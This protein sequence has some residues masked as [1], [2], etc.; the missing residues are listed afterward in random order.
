MLPP[1][2]GRA[3]ELT[4]SRR[5]P[6]VPN[7]VS[8]N[9]ELDIPNDDEFAPFSMFTPPTSK[10]RGR[11]AAAPG[12]SRFAGQASSVLPGSGFGSQGLAPFTSYGTGYRGREYSPSSNRPTKLSRGKFTARGESHVSRQRDV[13]PTSSLTQNVQGH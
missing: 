6:P 11:L 3:M 9:T 10:E 7:L 4:H 13:L 12:P 8:L 2:R 1:S 5:F